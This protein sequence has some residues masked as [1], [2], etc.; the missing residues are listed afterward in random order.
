MI[1]WWVTRS[2]RPCTAF[3]SSRPT[4]PT[5]SPT[6]RCATSFGRRAR[7]RVRS[8]CCDSPTLQP[9]NAWR[10]LAWTCYSRRANVPSP[11][12]CCGRTADLSS[13]SSRT[14]RRCASMC[15]VRT[16]GTT[17]VSTGAMVRCPRGQGPRH[18]THA[19]PLVSRAFT[20]ALAGGV[21][22]QFERRGEPAVFCSGSFCAHKVELRDAK[23]PPS[24]A[25]PAPSAPPCLPD[26]P[27]A[28][29]RCAE[30]AQQGE[31][32][33]NPRHMMRHCAE[34]CA[35]AELQAGRTA[36]CRVESCNSEEC[37]REV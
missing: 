2:S 13:Y 7:H 18:C 37:G 15:S 5:R 21:N 19:R 31:C 29:A 10:T 3:T 34:S 23:R 8:S 16:M 17:S 32:V 14:T 28:A 1:V 36:E 25:T 33:F 35:R 9:A 20:R 30:W 4:C 11:T 27:A 12:G 6:C 22:Q 24:V 26:S